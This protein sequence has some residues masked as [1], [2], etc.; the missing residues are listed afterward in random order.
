M[1]LIW[2]LLIVGG[3]GF[4]GA[5]LRYLVGGWVQGLFARP[6]PYGTFAVN[7]AGCFA[8]GLVW[9][10]VENRDLLNPAIRLFILTGM[11]G[12]FTTFST[13]SL[14]TYNLVR[15]GDWLGAGLNAGLSVFLGLLAAALAYHLSD[16]KIV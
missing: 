16:P 11:L 8:I 10:L 4:L 9:G 2:K 13:F 12:G 6:W 5:I 7:I 14:E 1:S 3:G 15:Q